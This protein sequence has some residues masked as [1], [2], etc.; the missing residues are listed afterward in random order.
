MIKAKLE[1]AFASYPDSS[2]FYVAYSGGL[3]STVLLHLA[4]RAAKTQSSKRRI[5]LKAIHVHHGISAHAD[6]WSEHCR[7]E[8]E[9]L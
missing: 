1:R 5:Q 9:R 6:R 4:K 7:A 8:C 2:T 3:D